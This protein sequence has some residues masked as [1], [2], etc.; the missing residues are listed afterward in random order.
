MMCVRV[1]AACRGALDQ[2]WGA[3]GPD[4]VVTQ[5]G[6][7]GGVPVQPQPEGR[8]VNGRGYTQVRPIDTS[9]SMPGDGGSNGTT[10][11]GNTSSGSTSSG[12]GVSGS[13][14]SGG[15]SGG[16]DRTAVPRGPGGL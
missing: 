4:W 5:P 6:I 1:H 16:G 13:G 3:F 8:V 9:F 12:G 15:F 2:R 7:G 11:T 14:Y 10:S